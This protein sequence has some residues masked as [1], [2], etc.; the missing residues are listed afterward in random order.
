[1]AYVGL[2]G[3]GDDVRCAGKSARW[4]GHPTRRLLSRWTN[5]RTC[6]PV[7]ALVV[8]CAESGFENPRRWVAC[9]RCGHLL[10]PGHGIATRPGV[11]GQAEITRR[12]ASATMVA[13]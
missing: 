5:L 4:L 6:T 1:R 13:G 9:A 7:A 10:G 2:N 8:R 11:V 3:P 12:A